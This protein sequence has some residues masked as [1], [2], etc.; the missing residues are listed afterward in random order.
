VTWLLWIAV[1]ALLVALVA[2]QVRGVRALQAWG[3]EPSRG[4]LVLRAVN[5]L[6]VIALAA[7]ALVKWVN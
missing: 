7:F 5:T 4:V 6:A 1:G 2:L 3:V